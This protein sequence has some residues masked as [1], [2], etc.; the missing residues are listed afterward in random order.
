MLLPVAQHEKIFSSV[1]KSFQTVQNLNYLSN[2]YH[3]TFFDY[4][5]EEDRDKSSSVSGQ[6]H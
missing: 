3:I 5:F 4:L 6:K 1:R 2:E